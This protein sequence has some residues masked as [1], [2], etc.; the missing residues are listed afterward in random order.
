MA[1]DPESNQPLTN[2]GNPE[3]KVKGIRWGKIFS[4]IE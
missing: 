2:N 3:Y 1:I 4:W